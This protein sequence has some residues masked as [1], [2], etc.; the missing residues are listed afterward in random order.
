MGRKSLPIMDPSGGYI[1]YI[2]KEYT[3]ARWTEGNR[4]WGRIFHKG[5]YPCKEKQEAGYILERIY[6]CEI[7][8]SKKGYSILSMY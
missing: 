4:S 1:T 8:T 7:N 5:I 6:L 2:R 3:L